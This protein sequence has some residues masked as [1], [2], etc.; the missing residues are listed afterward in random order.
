SDLLIDAK[1][2]LGD[3]YLLLGD[4]EKAR[5]NFEEIVRSYP[6][7]QRSK[8]SLLKLADL[9]EKEG[10]IKKA[11]FYYKEIIK[12]FPDSEE[13]LRAGERLKFLENE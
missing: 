8:E 12:R 2:F 5:L 3:S 10:N 1:Y 4:R 11:K 6:N 13:A 9:E 7:S